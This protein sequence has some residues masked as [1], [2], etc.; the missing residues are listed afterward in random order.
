MDAILSTD[1]FLGALMDASLAGDQE[2]I[3]ALRAL[4]EAVPSLREALRD[5]DDGA[6]AAGE[7]H[8]N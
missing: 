7:R 8:T 1:E 4:A 6:R 2:K 3:D 5:F